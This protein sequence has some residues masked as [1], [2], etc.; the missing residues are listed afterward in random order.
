MYPFPY[1]DVDVLR[2][3]AFAS[4]LGAAAASLPFPHGVKMDAQLDSAPSGVD[5]AAVDL[6]F[7]IGG[8]DALTKDDAGKKANQDWYF[9]IMMKYAHSATPEFVIKSNAP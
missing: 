3:S 7:G 4:T 9:E 5:G 8:V 2:S 6:L 1:H